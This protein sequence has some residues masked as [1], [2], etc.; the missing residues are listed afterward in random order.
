MVSRGASPILW[1]VGFIEEAIN[2]IDYLTIPDGNYDTWLL[3]FG[4]ELI[5]GTLEILSS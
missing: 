4:A 5:T 3:Y 2:S 1:S